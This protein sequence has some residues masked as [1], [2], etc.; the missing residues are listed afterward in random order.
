MTS[1]FPPPGRF[2]I[3]LVDRE[4]QERFP[5][6]KKRRIRNK[7]RKD[8]RNWA[9]LMVPVSHSLILGSAFVHIHYEKP[10]E[11]MSRCME[12]HSKLWAKLQKTNPDLAELCDIVEQLH[13]LKFTS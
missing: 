7:W 10:R 11:A 4:R 2:H 5:R 12:M 3:T 13:D 1:A 6:S 9:P 8:R